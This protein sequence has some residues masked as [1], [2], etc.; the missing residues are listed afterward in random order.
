MRPPRCLGGQGHRDRRSRDEGRCA[1]SRWRRM[2][3]RDGGGSSEI[4]VCRAPGCTGPHA[5]APTLLVRADSRGPVEAHRRERSRACQRGANRYRT[6]PPILR[7]QSRSSSAAKLLAPGLGAGSDRTSVP[8]AK[9]SPGSGRT[10]SRERSRGRGADSVERR[11]SWRGSSERGAG[12]R[13]I[14]GVRRVPKPTATHGSGRALPGCPWASCAARRA[15]PLRT[16]TGSGA[17]DSGPSRAPREIRPQ[18][19]RSRCGPQPGP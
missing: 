12:D 7:R 10:R 5:I 16:R 9:P 17:D 13:R 18:R 2:L 3:L 4:R 1:D 14:G 8:T 6:V 19:V 11:S 15:G